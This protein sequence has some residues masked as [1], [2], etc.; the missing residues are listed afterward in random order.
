MS[1]ILPDVDVAQEISNVAEV[2]DRL[3]QIQRNFEVVNEMLGAALVIPA[4]SVGTAELEDDS[5]T[6]AKLLTSYLAVAASSSLTLTTTPTDVPGVSIAVPVAGS[7][8]YFAVFDF[9]VTV[10]N[11]ACGGDVVANGVAQGGQALFIPDPG[12]I[13]RATPGT[14]GVAVGLAAG[15]IV[16]L[17]GRKFA[18]TGTAAAV[19]TH[20]KL[21]LIGPL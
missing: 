2:N 4:G 10:A 3:R 8:A 15:N 20:T 18:A 6:P 14:V 7:Y 19:V 5:V 21:L 1:Q 13:G 16:K 17:Q 12:V 9:D 11:A